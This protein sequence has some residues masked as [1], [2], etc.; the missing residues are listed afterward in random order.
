MAAGFAPRNSRFALPRFDIPAFPKTKTNQ[1]NLL[2]TM[3]ATIYRS[4]AISGA[5]YGCPEVSGLICTSFS[6]SETT[7]PKQFTDDQGTV[8]GMA[9]PEP[10]QEI[11]MEGI[12]T[13][14]FSVTVGDLL[15]ITMPAGVTLGATTIVTGLTTTYAA[16]Q[17]EK[18]SMKAQSF[19]TAMTAS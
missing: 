3:A 18:I 9:V 19:K 15:A 14:S 11:S 2:H 4:S 5:A 13:G 17:L 1:L 7:S 12:R 16:E 10:I 8:I 6:V